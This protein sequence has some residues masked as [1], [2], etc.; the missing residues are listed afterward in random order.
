MLLVPAGEPVDQCIDALIP[1]LEP[2]DVIVDGG[3]THFS[4]TERRTRYVESKG[5]LYVG[6]GV[7][8]GEEGALRGPSLM[9]GGSDNAWPLVRPIFQAIAAKV[10]PNT[11]SPAANGSARAVPATTSK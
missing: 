6:A 1:L 2:G 4:D 5:L 10:G 9:P 8:G 11:M 7:S 3:N